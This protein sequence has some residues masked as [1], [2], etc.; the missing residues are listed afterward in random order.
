MRLSFLALM[1][2]RLLHTQ[3]VRGPSSANTFN[4]LGSSDEKNWAPPVRKRQTR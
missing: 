3:V 2:E 4:N 1:A